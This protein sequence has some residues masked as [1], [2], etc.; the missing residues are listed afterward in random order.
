MRDIEE[1]ISG[2]VDGEGCFTV[3]FNRRTAMQVG[4]ELRPSF[5]VSQNEDRRQVIDIVHSYFGCGYVRRDYSDKTVKFEIRD[6]HQLMTKVIPHF[7]KYPLLSGKQKD[8]L[9]FREICGLI[10]HKQHLSHEGFARIVKLAYQMNGSGK[11][12]RAKEEILNNL[13][14]QDE[15][16]VLSLS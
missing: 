14:H 2:Y 13:I 10:K 11:R 3:T 5:S 9:L 1:Y 7:E 4:W 15:D 12:K 8:F 16:I 6:H